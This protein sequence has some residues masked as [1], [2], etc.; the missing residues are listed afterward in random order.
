MSERKFIPEDIGKIEL[1]EAVDFLRRELSELIKSGGRKIKEGNNGIII[2]L[3]EGLVRSFFKKQNLDVSDSVVS[4]ILKIYRAGDAEREAGFQ[5]DAYEIIEKAKL[6][7]PDLKYADIPKMHLY[8]TLE[9]GQIKDF[10]DHE[11][12]LN[13]KVGEK[14]E[15]IIMDEMPGE[16][17]AT[18]MYREILNKVLADRRL[19]QNVAD[20]ENWSKEDFD[21]MSFENLMLHVGRALKLETP[22][23]KDIVDPMKMRGISQR[24]AKKIKKHIGYL[25]VLADIFERLK[26][27]VKVLHENGLYHRDLHERNVMVSGSGKD[28]KVSL[29]DFG[30]AAKIGGNT[31]PY[32]GKEADFMLDET[33]WTVYADLAKK[34]EKPSTKIDANN[35]RIIGKKISDAL[36]FLGK[37]G[38]TSDFNNEISGVVLSTDQDEAIKQ[39]EEIGFWV[40]TADDLGSSLVESL[41]IFELLKKI[42]SEQRQSLLE[43][44]AESR[45]PILKGF[46]DDYGRYLM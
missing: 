30:S 27:T 19:R 2:S 22:T 25:P 5:N 16:D 10:L 39:L 8:Q 11:C 41:A 35:N 7:N 40:P 3:E 43:T 45:N 37:R 46:Q 33:L 32:E 36:S 24:N 31:D 14:I 44:I 18:V 38:K 23:A 4:K 20:L 34:P 13:G 6:H 1:T 28:L 26:N 21:N 15:V 12:G 9:T 29:I 42:N 17:L